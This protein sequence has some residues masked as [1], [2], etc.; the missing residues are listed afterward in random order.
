MGVV[1]AT[2]RASSRPRRSARASIWWS[3]S[4]VGR[5]LPPPTSQGEAVQGHTV[6]AQGEGHAEEVFQPLLQSGMEHRG[7]RHRQS[8]GPCQG[9]GPEGQFPAG[10]A[11][12]PGV[13]CVLAGKEGE[14]HI[15]EP[16]RQEALEAALL[17]QHTVGGKPKLH[18]REAPV[19]MVQDL[20]E[21]FVEERFT[22]CECQPGGC[23]F[24]QDPVQEGA[25]LPRAQS[26]GPLVP[27]VVAEDTVQIA[28]P[29]ELVDE[30]QAHGDPTGRSRSAKRASKVG[31]KASSCC[32]EAVWTTWRR[33]SSC[34]VRSAG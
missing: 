19:D 9:Q 22:P 7:H 24:R 3:C 25:G 18:R 20:L 31:W 23:R 28:A 27:G 17:Q 16:S 2:G 13:V 4:R 30:P 5:R 11:R 1:T 32:R 15:A 29:C 10:A 21:A 26:L 12:E 8:P 34:S 6:C 14:L 33:R